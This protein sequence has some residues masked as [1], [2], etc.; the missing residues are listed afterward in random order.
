MGEM[1]Y[2]QEHKGNDLLMH[3]K[4][5]DAS[6][7]ELKDLTKNVQIDDSASGTLSDSVSLAIPDN[8]EEVELYGSFTCSW[9]TPYSAASE[10]VAVKVVLESKSDP[11][12][13]SPTTEPSSAETS[14]DYWT[15]LL[16]TAHRRCPV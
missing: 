14:E 9:R 5:Y 8:V 12:P 4:C 13:I 7:R 1:G 16:S 2:Q 15:P 3:I 11:N 6:G 10:M